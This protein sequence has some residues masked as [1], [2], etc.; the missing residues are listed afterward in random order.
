MRQKIDQ[1][2][3]TLALAEAQAPI[4]DL[5]RLADWDRAVDP[6]I[7]TIGA[8]RLIAPGALPNDLQGWIAFAKCDADAVE[9]Y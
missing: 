2:R 3:E 7:F 1:M 8:Q 4:A 5:T 9:L 6:T